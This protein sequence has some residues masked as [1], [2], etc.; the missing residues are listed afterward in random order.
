MHVL[1]ETELRTASIVPCQ[2][3]PWRLRAPESTCTQRAK[4][5]PL[6]CLQVLRHSSFSRHCLRAAHDI[7]TQPRLLG[8]QTFGKTERSPTDPVCLLVPGE[9]GK[10]DSWEKVHITCARVTFHMRD[11]PPWPAWYSSFRCANTSWGLRLEAAQSPSSGM[12][13][14]LHYHYPKHTP[15]CCVIYCLSDKV[16]KW[17][18]TC[19]LC[20]RFQNQGHRQGPWRNRCDTL[21]IW[22]TYSG[23]VRGG[24][25]VDL[26]SLCKWKADWILEVLPFSK[27]AWQIQKPMQKI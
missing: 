27:L 16:F 22:S 9:D 20:K 5:R 3:W 11:V 26:K 18:L 10:Y 15:Q 4:E 19:R 12:P 8:Y 7:Q 6:V 17:V 14:I 2:A 25:G 24:R 23:A 21:F 13:A 1:S